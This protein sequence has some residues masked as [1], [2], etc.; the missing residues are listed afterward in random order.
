MGSQDDLD[1]AAESMDAQMIGISNGPP[2]IMIDGEHLDDKG[3]KM[4]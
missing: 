1:K 2:E 4:M 3:R